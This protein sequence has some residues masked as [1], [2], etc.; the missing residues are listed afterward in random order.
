MFM[1]KKTKLFTKNYSDSILE[2]QD[3]INKADK[4]IIGAGSGLSSSAGLVYDG[5]RFDKYFF[6]FKQKYG[7]RD[8]YSG[9]FYSFPTQE[10]FWAFWSRVIWI[11]RYMLAPKKTY[12]N[13]RSLIKD[14]DYF[15]ITTNVDH[16]FQKNGFDKKRLFYTQG[17]YGLFEKISNNDQQTYDNYS[18]I[19]KMILAQGFQ[20]LKNNEL[21]ITSERIKMQIPRELIPKIDNSD[22]RLNLRI[23]DNFVQDKGWHEAA[24]RYKTF[25]S[26]VDLKHVLYLEVGVGMNTPA[27]I[28][29]PFWELTVE[30]NWANYVSISQGK[31]YI[32]EQVVDRSLAIKADIDDAFNRLLKEGE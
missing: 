22:V 11:N 27:I 31:I 5:A 6:D 26:N 19:K 28:K 10:E 25:L 14:K 8:M 9:G 29:Y 18:F 2:L 24:K 13:L 23:D 30:N 17:D 12:Q 1:R 20:I 4:I 3:L 32:P 21:A 16:Q 7:I 15:V